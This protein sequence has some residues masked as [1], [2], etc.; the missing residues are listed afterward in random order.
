[1]DREPHGPV[2][3]L[4]SVYSPLIINVH[5]TVTVYQIWEHKPIPKPKPSTHPSATTPTPSLGPPP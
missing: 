4:E 3:R 5:V 1:M 2:Y